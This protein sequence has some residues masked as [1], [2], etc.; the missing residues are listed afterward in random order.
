MFDV[1]FDLETLIAL[2][3]ERER[4][5]QYMAA[6]AQKA[7]KEVKSAEYTISPMNKAAALEDTTSTVLKHRIVTPLS[8]ARK[9]VTENSVPSVNDKWVEKEGREAKVPKTVVVGFEV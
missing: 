2:R 9:D 4:C 5:D 8:P 3:S 7:L 1:T 6:E